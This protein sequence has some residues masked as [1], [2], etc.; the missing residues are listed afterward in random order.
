M[1][2]T[3]FDTVIG[4]RVQDKRFWPFTSSIILRSKVGTFWKKVSN[5]K[6]APYLEIHVVACKLICQYIDLIKSWL[7]YSL[8]H[9]GHR[10]LHL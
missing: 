10:Y 8:S 6:C 9:F 7:I 1:G 3:L 4:I 2:S 5:V